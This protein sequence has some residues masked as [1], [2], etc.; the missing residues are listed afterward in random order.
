MTEVRVKKM[1]GSERE[2]DKGSETCPSYCNLV[3]KNTSHLTPHL[4]DPVR[5]E[6]VVSGW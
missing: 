4:S 1:E 2:T 3:D 6:N 5:E